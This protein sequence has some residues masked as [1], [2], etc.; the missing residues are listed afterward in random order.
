MSLAD[1]D[2]KQKYAGTGSQT[3]FA[4]NFDFGDTAQIKVVLV[5]N[6]GAETLLTITTHYTLTG[7]GPDNVEMVT[8]PDADQFLVV[9]RDAGDINQPDSYTTPV[10]SSALNARLDDIYRHLQELDEKAAR[11]FTARISTALT[12][13]ELPVPS[14]DLYLGWNTAATDLENKTAV[15]GATGAT[16]A[17]GA[18]G[19]TGS[20]G[21]TGSTGANGF[22]SAL[23]SKIEAEAGTDNTKGMSPLRVAEAII[24]QIAATPSHVAALASIATN[25]LNI[26]INSS[27]IAKMEGSFVSTLNTGQQALLNNTATKDMEGHDVLPFPDTGRG[28]RCE[29]SPVGAKSAEVTFEVFRKDDAETRFTKHYLELHYI[30]GTWY[31]S[32][33]DELLIIGNP[34][35]MTFG[36]TTNG[37]GVVLLNYTSDN[38]V[39]GNYDVTS[40][41]RWQI[42]ELS[43][44]TI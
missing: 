17:A 7:S 23:A 39:G 42:R 15:A 43:A 22:F 29:L 6:V 5:D 27:K 26:A 25:V 40:T 35:G 38:M 41:I 44:T 13:L 36:I 34:S 10:S 31:L 12:N 21:L 3:T 16:G 9:Y 28:G 14:S 24:A 37:A 11:A 1:L 33:R 2:V 4:I 18:T 19:A 8:A 30:N 20:I 32:E